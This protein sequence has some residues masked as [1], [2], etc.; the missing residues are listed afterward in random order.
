MKH[1]RCV[2]IVSLFLLLTSL[3]N[4]QPSMVRV[5]GEIRNAGTEPLLIEV[6]SLQ[7]HRLV[8]T[9]Q[10]DH[11]HFAL[12][13]VPADDYEFT[14]L[15]R[16]G[17]VVARQMVK[18]Q[19]NG[20]PISILLPPRTETK[21]VSGVVSLSRLGNPVS[22]KALREYQKGSAAQQRGKLDDALSHYQNA[23]A[24]DPD[25]PEALLSLGNIYL[26]QRR[27]ADAEQTLRRAA[28]LDPASPLIQMSFAVSLYT[29]Q[30]LPEAEEAAKAALRGRPDLTGARYLL[31]LVLLHL[32][33]MEEALPHLKLAA[34]AHPRA[35]RILE[36]LAN[37]PA[38]AAIR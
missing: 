34:K 31:G 23:L 21:P 29:V 12:P 4:G 7:G 18:V 15:D 28:E 24:I 37:P 2:H 36:S 38:S 13:M 9:A 27:Y 22:K 16:T 25:F 19:P 32:G 33:R 3:S 10:V 11:A 1:H 8:A 17:R 30:K 6:Y 5:E 14:V 26:Q 35:A 20:I